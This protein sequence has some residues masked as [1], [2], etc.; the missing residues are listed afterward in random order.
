MVTCPYCHA[1]ADHFGDHILCCDR[2]EFYTRHEAVVNIL[3]RF[4]RASGDQVANDVGIHGRKRPADL[5]IARWSEE[6]PVAVDI[7]VT[8][9]L[10]PCLGFNV[11]LAR[12]AVAAKERQTFAKYAQLLESGDFKLIPFP[13]F[14]FGELSS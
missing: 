13:I 9:P 14:T 7:P 8:H 5:F 3:T 1:T 10:A 11:R 12:G 6:L 4:I 2:V